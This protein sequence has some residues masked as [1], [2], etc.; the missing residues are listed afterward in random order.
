[1]AIFKKF[2]LQA[3]IASVYKAGGLILSG[4]RPLVSVKACLSFNLGK[5][6]APA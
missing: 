3:T 5:Q 2:L 4:V 1:M 6:Q